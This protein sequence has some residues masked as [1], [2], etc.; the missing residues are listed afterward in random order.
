MSDGEEAR[1]D[2]LYPALGSNGNC[3]LIEAMK[4]ARDEEGCVSTDA[5][6]RLSVEGLYAAGDIVA[7]LDQ[8]SVAMGHGAVAATAM[9]NDLRAKDGQ[10]A[11]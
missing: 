2:T 3:E 11:N 9:H 1:F 5:H 10:T 7:A 8:I 4:V 6:Q